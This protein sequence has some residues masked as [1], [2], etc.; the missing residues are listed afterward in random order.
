MKL[1]FF[2]GARTVTGSRFLF[3]INGSRLL[4]E[5]GLYQ[6]RRKDTYERNLSFPFPPESVDA[7]VLSHAH[8]DHSGNL[9][10][11]VK[12]GFAGPIYATPATI[13][14]CRL[15]LLDSAYIQEKDVEF[16]NKIRRRHGEP[17]VEPLYDK[18][19]AEAALQRFEPVEYVETREIAPGVSLTFRDA[20][21]ILGSAQVLLECNEN[22]RTIR[23]GFSGDLGRRDMPVLRDPDYL[24]DLDYLVLE[25]TYGNR[26][27]RVSGDVAEELAQ[28]V[29]STA[30]QGGKIIVPAFAVGRTQLLVYLLHKLWDQ[31]RIPDMPIYVDS[32]LAVNIT[33]V[34]RNHPECLDRETHRIFLDNHEDPFGFRRLHYVRD[35]EESKRLNSLAVPHIVISASGMA[36]GGRILHHLRNNIGNPRNVVLLVGFAAEQTLARKLMD[37]AE[38][39][40]IFGEEHRVRCRVVRMDDFSAHA[41]RGGLLELLRHQPVQRLRGLFLVHGEE[42]QSEAFAQTAKSLGYRSVLVPSPGDAVKIE[43]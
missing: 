13:D 36:E 3:H 10:N 31:G 28:L 16:V 30:Q 20:G 24:R 9:P 26:I 11:L 12:Q 34:F 2:G 6:G 18:A 29:R 32:P 39:V 8:I 19:A 38:T 25:T 5:C 41:D 7:V 17:P 43:F 42:D 21:H 14:L 35:V 27:H 1:Q 22:G 23:L 33:E 15:M 40:R 37:G 4:L